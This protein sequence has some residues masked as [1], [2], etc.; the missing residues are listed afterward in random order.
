MEIK[1]N[2]SGENYGKYKK[3]THNR[4]SDWINDM[5]SNWMLKYIWFV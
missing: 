4:T 2:I 3:N 5:E 1:Q